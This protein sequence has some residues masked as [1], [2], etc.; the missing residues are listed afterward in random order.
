MVSEFQS[1]SPTIITCML[2]NDKIIFDRYYCI[3]SEQAKEI[4]VHYNLQFRH[5]F[6]RVKAFILML[7]PDG[8][9]FLIISTCF[10]WR[11][12]TSII[13]CGE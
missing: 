11:P 12:V 9:Q 8:F 5:I 2:I 10:Q 13:K 1:H 3:N 6:I 7:V 4:M